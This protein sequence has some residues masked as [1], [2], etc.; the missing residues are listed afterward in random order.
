[1]KARGTERRTFI[2][3]MRNLGPYS[4]LSPS[5]R[6]EC[7]FFPKVNPSPVILTSRLPSSSGTVSQNQPFP[8]TLYFCPFYSFSLAQTQVQDSQPHSNFHS[9]TPSLSLMPDVLQEQSVL[10]ASTSCH[11]LLNPG[12]LPSFVMLS[13]GTTHLLVT[14][15]L[16]F[17]SPSCF[18]C[19]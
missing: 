17:S 2:L 4:S 12:L 11:S 10:T 19:L 9:T 16:Q 13:E 6:E 7:S 18:C 8:L 14:V 3:Q 15:L 1:M 5:Q